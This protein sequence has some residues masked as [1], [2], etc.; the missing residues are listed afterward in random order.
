MNQ[1]VAGYLWDDMYRYL[2]NNVELFH[3]NLVVQ[4]YVSAST[5]LDGKS[6]LVLVCSLLD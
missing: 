1:Y 6:R 4:K 5:Y 2:V 3:L